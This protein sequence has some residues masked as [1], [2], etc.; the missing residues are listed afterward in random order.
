MELGFIHVF[1]FLLDSIETSVR[2]LFVAKHEEFP[3]LLDSIETHR[4]LGAGEKPKTRFHS[5]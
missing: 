1:P 4:G 5:S 2:A 3:F